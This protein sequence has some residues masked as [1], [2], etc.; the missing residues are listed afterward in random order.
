VTLMTSTGERQVQDL[1]AHLEMT[2]YNRIVVSPFSGPGK[3]RRF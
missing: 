2:D 1:L 3:P